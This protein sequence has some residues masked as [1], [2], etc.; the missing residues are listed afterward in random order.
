MHEAKR[1]KNDFSNSLFKDLLAS[2]MH[3]FKKDF[4]NGH[5]HMAKHS[6]M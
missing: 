4:I 2:N 3:Q 5:Y 6:V 1:N